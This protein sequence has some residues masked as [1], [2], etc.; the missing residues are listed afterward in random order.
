VCSE[1]RAVSAERFTLVTGAA[2]FIGGRLVERLVRDGRKVRV[3]VRRVNSTIER[4]RDSVDIAVGDI[5]DTAAVRDACR[6]V[7]VAY[8]LAALAK[9][10][11]KDPAEFFDVNVTG[12]YNVCRAAEELGVRRLV[13]MSTAL[14]CPPPGE[15]SGTNVTKLTI[16]QRSKAEGE[17]MVRSFLDRGGDAVIVRPARV[18]GPGMQTPGNTVTRLVDLYRRGRFRFRIS[19]YNA[20][21]NYVLVDDVVDG[22]QRAE[23]HG[24]SGEAYALGGADCTLLEFLEKIEHAGA[25][26]RHVVSVP[27]PIAGI[28]AFAFELSGFLGFEPE[29]SRDWVTLLA[30]DWPVSSE[31]AERALGYIPTP[32]DDSVRITLEWLKEGRQEATSSKKS[33]GAVA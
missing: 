28:V 25:K 21:A 30:V 23:R 22:M 24:I 19:D 9:P 32:L 27:L 7:E 6:N 17:S 2:G 33:G 16:Y 8:H 26:R 11:S 1:L 18:F 10:W 12:T 29:I 15:R 5:R 3:F 13:H 31:K 4:L 14:V 20:R